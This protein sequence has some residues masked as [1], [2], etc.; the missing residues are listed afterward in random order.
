MPEHKDIPHLLAL[1]DDESDWIG[2]QVSQ[3]LLA[4]GA[5][6]EPLTRG[7]RTQLNSRQLARLD[8]TCRKW[9]NEAF[10]RQ[11]QHWLDIDDPYE[12]LEVAFNQLAYFHNDFEPVPL[13]AEIDALA[14]RFL[15]SSAPREPE[16]LMRFLFFDEGFNI[17]H[18]DVHQPGYH[19][20]HAILKNKKGEQLSLT[21]LAILLGRRLGL[22]LFGMHVPGHFML[23]AF[24]GHDIQL[25]N[26]SNKGQP[27]ART[28]VLYLEETFRRNDTS[29]REMV[30][31][32]YEMVLQNLRNI[33]ECH[34]RKS[35]NSQAQQYASLYES[36]MQQLKLRKLVK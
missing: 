1:L 6:L 20:L 16:A 29:A 28:S 31:S 34:C 35:Q 4:F 15:A 8:A 30:A 10:F 13:G 33:I 14:G 2:E 7:Y 25:Y 9:K 23:A 11:W 5:E 24:E 18:T 3:A 32:P 12:A 27:V 22:E 17:P 21:V 19:D 26:T 36:L